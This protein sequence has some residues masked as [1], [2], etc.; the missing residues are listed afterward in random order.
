MNVE[1]E[2]IRLHARTLKMP[3]IPRGFESLSRDARENGWSYEYFLNAV[4]DAEIHAR[5]ESVIRSRIRE[6]RFPE[7]K[8]IDTFN[9]NELHGIEPGQIGE[10]ATCSY[11]DEHRNLILAGP[12][13]TGKTHLAIALGIEAARRRKT[14]VFHRT[15]D[16]V[17]TLIEARDQRQLGL[18]HRRLQKAQ[19]LILDELGFIPFDRQ[20]GE[21]LFNVISDRYERCSVLITT[22]LSFSEWP[23]V[24]GG[25]EK[26]TTALLDRLTHHASILT[27]SG[28]S[29]RLKSRK[30]S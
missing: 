6:A 20:G 18:M 4:L 1:H 29:F 22:N 11:I 19:L 7:V 26:L 25:D 23:Q 5:H 30:K 28:E 27:T 10:L 24:F 16:L 8:T 2:M 17:R 3:S 15:A 21:L 14:V 12:I 13:G 9:V